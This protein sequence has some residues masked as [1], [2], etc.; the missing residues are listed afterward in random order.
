[1]AA[2]DLRPGTGCRQV[3][4][5]RQAAPT[6]IRGRQPWLGANFHFHGEKNRNSDP[7]GRRCEGCVHLPRDV[8]GG[9]RAHKGECPGGEADTALAPCCPSTSWWLW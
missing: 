8:L 3:P 5:L 1:M 2:P 7:A 9:R 4:Q 6:Q